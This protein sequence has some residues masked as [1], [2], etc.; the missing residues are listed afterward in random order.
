MDNGRTR[1]SNLLWATAIWED[2]GIFS[3]TLAAADDD[4]AAAVLGLDA[5][6]TSAPG[7]TTVSL[8]GIE[9]MVTM[10][11]LEELLTGRSEDEVTEN[12]RQG[13]V[14]ADGP[15]GSMV[16]AITA[17]LQAGL[18]AATTIVCARSRSTGPAPRSWTARPK[19]S[20]TPSWIWPTSPGPRP[21]GVTRSTAG[22][23]NDRHPPG[24]R[25]GLA[26]D[27][28]VLQRDVAAGETY[29]YPEG[30]SLDEARPLWM[31][32][33]PGGTVVAEADGV[34]LGSAKMG[35]NR[36]SRGA[37]IATASFMIDPSQQG[38]GI[39][40][41]LGQHVVDWA[42]AAGYHG[43]QFNAVVETNR[44]RSRCGGR[45]ASRSSPQC[46]GSVRQP[47]PRPG[48]AAHHV[49]AVLLLFWTPRPGGA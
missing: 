12:P 37:H 24:H 26:A 43:M 38:R 47:G 7:Y 27:L 15:D 30:L 21:T 23:T 44:P 46:P 8:P 9:P 14:I 34:V 29:A 3:A 18:G 35:P 22:S 36:P 45:W 16:V 10:Q 17:E 40:R 31:E 13:D 1:G 11:T 20:A 25:R 39:G 19:P 33:P 48:R 2:L 32:P 42:R 5:G 6:P 41:E 28:P 49:P 4:A